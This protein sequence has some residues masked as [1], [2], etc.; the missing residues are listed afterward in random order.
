M[1]IIKRVNGGELMLNKLELKCL[2][3]VLRF[4]LRE[5]GFEYYTRT[6]FDKIETEKL[7]Y[8]LENGKPADPQ[9]FS[10][11]LREIFNLRQNYVEVLFGITVEDFAGLF[12]MSKETLMTQFKLLAE[13]EEN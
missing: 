8:R 3:Q 1:Q 12:G 13:Y 7:I 6:G 4:T 2:I 5:L 10:L 11:S 9:R